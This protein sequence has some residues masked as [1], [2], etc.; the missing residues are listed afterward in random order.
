MRYHVGSGAFWSFIQAWPHRAFCFVPVK[1]E[2]SQLEWTADL[3]ADIS[4][5]ISVMNDDS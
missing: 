5:A 3:R 2:T 4:V 1:D